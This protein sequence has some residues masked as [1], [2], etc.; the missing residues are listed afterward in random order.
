V[1]PW[2]DHK[3]HQLEVV[4]QKGIEFLKKG[5]RATKGASKEKTVVRQRISGMGERKKENRQRK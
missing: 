3:I 1:L 4:V 5:T 2:I